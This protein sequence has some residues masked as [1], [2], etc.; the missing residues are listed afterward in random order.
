[1]NKIKTNCK[2]IRRQVKQSKSVLY[3]MEIAMFLKSEH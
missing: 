2:T 3:R 1:M